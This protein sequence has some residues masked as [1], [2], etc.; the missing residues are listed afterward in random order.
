[1]EKEN[2]NLRREL[3]QLRAELPMPTEWAPGAP[4]APPSSTATYL[5]Q[6]TGAGDLRCAQV[7]P[8]LPPRRGARRR[9]PWRSGWPSWERATQQMVAEQA[10]NFSFMNIIGLLTFVVA[11]VLMLAMFVWL[12]GRVADDPRAGT[13]RQITTVV[14]PAGS[15]VIPGTVR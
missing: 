2:A 13:P 5:R 14:A 11:L 6:V 3:Q 4:A 8:S 7:T 1:M 10:S 15:T 9:A 12:P